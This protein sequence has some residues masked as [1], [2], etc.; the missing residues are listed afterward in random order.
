MTTRKTPFFQKQIKRLAKTYA[1]VSD[2]CQ[3][4]LDAFQPERCFDLGAGLFKIRVKNSDIPCGKSGGYRIIAFFQATTR[5]LVPLIMYS[6]RDRENVT[7]QEIEQALASVL[8]ELQ[9]ET[10]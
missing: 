7:E 1:H 9:D 10:A 3:E 4:A 5:V 8:Q 6:K 2:D